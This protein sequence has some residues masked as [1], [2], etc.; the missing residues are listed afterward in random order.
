M[1]KRIW[2]ISDT[3]L[4]CRAN[5]VMWLQLIDDY[6]FNF[7]IPLAKKNY[8]KGKRQSFDDM[9]KVYNHIY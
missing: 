1:A 3:H 2:M 8:K 4:G 7:Y 6:F 9:Q 5:S